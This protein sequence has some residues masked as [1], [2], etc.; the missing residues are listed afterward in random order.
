MR[1]ILII[2]FLPL[3]LILLPLRILGFRLDAALK[4]AMFPSEEIRAAKRIERALK[5]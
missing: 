2:L 5:K 1:F 4:D 3:Y